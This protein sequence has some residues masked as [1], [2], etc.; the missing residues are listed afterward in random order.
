MEL[1]KIN[2]ILEGW[3]NKVAPRE[4][5]K[6]LIEQVYNEREDQCNSCEYDSEVKQKTGWTT[7]RID[8]HCTSCGCTTSAKLRCLS[9][10]CPLK[11][12][13]PITTQLIEDEIKK[14]SK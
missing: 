11:K 8:R 3:K 6:E 13:L 9:C 2:Q 14:N 1:T 4:E 5:L 7:I 12:W 10:E